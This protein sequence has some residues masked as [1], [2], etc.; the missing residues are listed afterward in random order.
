MSR[1]SPLEEDERYKLLMEDTL[2]D[3]TNGKVCI[4]R[5]HYSPDMTPL[6]Y[7]AY[8]PI[9]TRTCSK[10]GYLNP[11]DYTS[12]HDMRNKYKL[13]E[14]DGEI[15]AVGFYEYSFVYLDKDIIFKV[16]PVTI[17]G[18]RMNGFYIQPPS[19]Q[20]MSYMDK[21]YLLK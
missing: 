15:R 21:D 14:K 6:S 20:D 9:S 3:F 16:I 19:Q 8:R 2:P 13:P 11:K 18:R 1:L 10:W 4:D 17:C 12:N 5:D 7:E